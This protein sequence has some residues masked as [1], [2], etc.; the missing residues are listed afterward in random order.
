MSNGTQ[1]REGEKVE[2]DKETKDGKVKR[3]RKTN[4]S[5][6]SHQPQM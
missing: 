2:R 1:E 3:K 5:G 4:R 6:D